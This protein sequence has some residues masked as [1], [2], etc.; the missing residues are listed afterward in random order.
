MND[1]NYPTKDPLTKGVT[2]PVNFVEIVRWPC[3][4]ARI[5]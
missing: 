5:G 4:P 1:E 2:A 3:W